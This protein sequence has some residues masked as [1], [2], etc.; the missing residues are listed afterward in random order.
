M[1]NRVQHDGLMQ[2]FQASFAVVC[3]PLD[4][5]TAPAS[6]PQLKNYERERAIKPTSN[7][8]LSF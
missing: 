6:S 1:L 7:I 8:P 4:T 3:G 2:V 5:E